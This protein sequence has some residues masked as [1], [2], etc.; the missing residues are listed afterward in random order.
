MKPVG[1]EKEIRPPAVR[2]LKQEMLCALFG[3]A[4]LVSVIVFRR[5]LNAFLHVFW[6][7]IGLVLIIQLLFHIVRSKI[8]R[9]VVDL[10]TLSYRSVLHKR[11]EYP[12]D[13]LR[14]K[15]I[16]TPA[17]SAYY[18]V[19]FHNE[20]RIALI[21]VGWDNTD[22]LYQKIRHKGKLS[23]AEKYYFGK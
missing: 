17:R 23:E 1:C 11:S 21:P 7:C 10:N 9:M 16:C 8:W 5:H 22:A 2:S 14:W 20:K 6:L 18:I 13:D 3:L 19:L 4:V 12:L 15:L